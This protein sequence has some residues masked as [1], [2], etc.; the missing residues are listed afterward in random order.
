MARSVLSSRRRPNRRVVRAGQPGRPERRNGKKR[1]LLAICT[2]VGIED[3]K[4][5]GT[6]R[7]R[8]KGGEWENTGVIDCVELIEHKFLTLAWV[9]SAFTAGITSLLLSLPLT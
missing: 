4:Y 7:I 8:A 9:I 5:R 2:E 3:Y 1:R 6:G